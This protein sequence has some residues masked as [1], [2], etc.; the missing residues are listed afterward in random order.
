M[1]KYLLLLMLLCCNYIIVKANSSVP[2]LQ[3]YDVIVSNKDGAYCYDYDYALHKYIITQHIDYGTVLHI[4]SK[5]S[6]YYR[7]ANYEN[8]YYLK[9]SDAMIENNDQNENNKDIN[10]NELIMMCLL[11]EKE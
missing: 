8:C 3:P 4:W 9:V 2:S 10:Y 1:K 5:N 7:I 11:I 6:V